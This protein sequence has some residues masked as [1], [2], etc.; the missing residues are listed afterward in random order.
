MN[1][2]QVVLDWVVPVPGERKP[3]QGRLAG[4]G[5][6]DQDLVVAVGQ[7]M[8]DGCRGGAIGKYAGIQER[9]SLFGALG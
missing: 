7:T 1:G 4:P 6:R 8:Q 5:I 2:P 3:V 9:F